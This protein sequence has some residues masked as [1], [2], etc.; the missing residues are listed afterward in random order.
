MYIMYGTAFS[1]QPHPLAI[2]PCVGPWVVLLLSTLYYYFYWYVLLVL[3]STTALLCTIT[4]SIVLLVYHITI[5]E[6]TRKVKTCFAPGCFSGSFNSLSCFV[7]DVC[8]T[9]MHSLL[10]TF[11]A[12]CWGLGKICLSMR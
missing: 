11:T 6:E 1:G 3:S 7:D 12:D 5:G 10:L 9:R 4:R 2:P 8:S